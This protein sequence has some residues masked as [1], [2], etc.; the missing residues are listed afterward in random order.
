M[1]TYD[2]PDFTVTQHNSK[3]SFV[4]KHDFLYNSILLYSSYGTADWL[5]IC[6]VAINNYR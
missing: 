3:Y 5:L 2:T 1:H 6:T 4:S